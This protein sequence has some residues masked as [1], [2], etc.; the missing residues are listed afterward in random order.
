MAELIALSWPLLIALGMWIGVWLADWSNV[1][2]SYGLA[3]MMGE[4]QVTAHKAVWLRSVK[5]E[6]RK[7]SFLSQFR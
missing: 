3:R 1:H 7:S 6:S 2:S 5:D 4:Q